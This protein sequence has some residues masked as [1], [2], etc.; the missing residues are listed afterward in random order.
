MTGIS[1]FANSVFGGYNFRNRKALYC[2]DL[3]KGER[4]MANLAAVMKDE[5]RRLARKEIKSHVNATRQAVARHRLEIAHLKQLLK[6]QEKKIAQLKK[7]S[8]AEA[9]EEVEDPLAGVRFSSRSVRAQRKRLNIS[10]E[11]YGRLIGVSGLTVYNW[12]HGKARPRKAQLAAL[13]AVRNL[14]R[15][16]AMERLEGLKSKKGRHAK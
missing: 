6:E 12:E 9:V 4:S 5:I 13:V 14:G 8:P 10:A 7:E 16:E 3:T 15:G 1:Y 2:H 11:D